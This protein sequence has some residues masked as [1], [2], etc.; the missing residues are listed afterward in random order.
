[1]KERRKAEAQGRQPAIF[2][3]VPERR[4]RGN[5]LQPNFGVVAVL[6]RRVGCPPGA[7][8]E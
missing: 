2:D 3:L 7:G 8:G 1:M 4:F 5:P 6:A